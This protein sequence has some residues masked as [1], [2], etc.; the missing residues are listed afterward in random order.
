MEEK[1]H[2]FDGENFKRAGV[3]IVEHLKK[4]NDSEYRFILLTDAAKEIIGKARDLIPMVNL[5]LIEMGN[6]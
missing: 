2:I 6:D 5:S 1:V 3:Q 4:E